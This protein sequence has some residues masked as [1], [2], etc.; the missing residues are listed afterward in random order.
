MGPLY[1]SLDDAQKRRFAVLARMG[2]PRGGQPGRFQRG[3][4]GGPPAWHRGQRRTDLTPDATESGTSPAPISF[5]RKADSTGKSPVGGGKVLFEGKT[6]D[7]R[8]KA[9]AETL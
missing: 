6:P 8:G 9:N 4:D 7:F 1:Q 5:G 2:G 3:R